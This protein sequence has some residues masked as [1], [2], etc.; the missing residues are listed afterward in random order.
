MIKLTTFY[1]FSNFMRV[2][3]EFYE[4]KA[5]IKRKSLTV[6]HEF[7]FK[8]ED[9]NEISDAF[10]GSSGQSNFSFWFLVVISLILTFFCA[11]LYNN[12]TWLR[13]GQVL[14][15]VSLFLFFSSFIRKRYIYL[16][17]KSENLLASIMQTHKNRDT[18]K[19]IIEMIKN[20]SESV[21]EISTAIPFPKTNFEFEYK[22]VDISNIEKT[23]DRFYEDKIIG[24]EK[25]ITGKSAYEVPYKKLSGK[26][27]RRKIS[28]DV[29]SL[30]LSIFLILQSIFSGLY[31]GFGIRYGAIS[32]LHITYTLLAMLVVSWF[33]NFIKLEVF[34]LYNKNGQVAYWAYINKNEKEKVEKIIEYVKSRIP[35]ENSESTPLPAEERE[36]ETI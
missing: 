2:T 28:N 22:Y 4:D 17:D 26:F 14:F 16:L 10:F 3:Q 30:A 34:A 31:F 13:I 7:E 23:T 9:V 8:Y 19:K 33:T 24:I 25:S 35:E 12:I 29:F 32:M 11:W 5:I 1:P 18:V 6:E 21:T 36:L 15:I 20:K 27:D